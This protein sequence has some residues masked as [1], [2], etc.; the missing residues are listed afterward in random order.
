MGK[1]SRPKPIRLPEKL[2]HVRKALGLSQ[3]EMVKK[4]G[5][6]PDLLRE[7]VSDFERGRRVPPL[8]VLLAYARAANVLVEALIDDDLDLPANLPGK[9]KK[10]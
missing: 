2:L 6:A 3:N 4:M 9:R 8:P 5:L 7:E 1:A 10:S